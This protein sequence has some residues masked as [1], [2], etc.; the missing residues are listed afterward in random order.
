MKLLRQRRARDLASVLTPHP[1]EAARLLGCDVAHVQSDRLAAAQAMADIT[2]SVVV[3]KGSGSVI[4]LSGRPPHI[5]G[6]GNA[7][8]ASGG[9]GDVLAGWL[10]G[11]W[12]QMARPT[13]GDESELDLAFAVASQA[14]AEH[15]AAAEPQRPGSL[16]ASELI[17]RLHQ[18]LSSR[19]PAP[20]K[21]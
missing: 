6:T 5:N 14:V 13:Q 1:L 18:R 11:C 3:L 15:G 19:G 12:T 8:L 21:V 10:G 7:A 16:S 2:S 9:T 17:E 20:A 4:A